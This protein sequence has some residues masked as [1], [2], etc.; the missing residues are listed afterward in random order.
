LGHYDWFFFR[1][2][3]DKIRKIVLCQ[4]KITFE[5]MGRSGKSSKSGS[6]IE[7]P[8]MSDSMS[9]S[10]FNSQTQSVSFV[11][12][13]NH[14]QH[15]ALERQMSDLFEAARRDDY[16]TI[17]QLVQG[18]L[19]LNH[20]HQL[21]TGL[22]AMHMA[23]RYGSWQSLDELLMAGAR[24]DIKTYVSFFQVTPLIISAMFAG[25]PYTK[26]ANHEKVIRRL[27]GK[28]NPSE[29]DTPNETRR[30]I[31]S[32]SDIN[33]LDGLGRTALHW[34]SIMGHR[35]PIDLLL[36]LG[37]D[38]DIRDNY[39][40]TALRY[41]VKCDMELG[42]GFQ[43]I[44][45]SML[46][47]TDLNS[48]DNKGQTILHQVADQAK[49]R[50]PF[51]RLT[52]KDKTTDEDVNIISLADGRE[53]ELIL[54]GAKH[55]RAKIIQM[56]IDKGVDKG[57][58]DENN[59]RASDLAVDQEFIKMLEVEDDKEV[60]AYDSNEENNENAEKEKAKEQQRHENNFKEYGMVL[61]GE[62]MKSKRWGKRDEYPN[63]S[64]IPSSMARESRRIFKK[65]DSV[66]VDPFLRETRE[67][68][69]KSL[70][71]KMQLEL[72]IP[73]ENDDE[74]DTYEAQAKERL[75][76][77]EILIRLLRRMDNISKSTKDGFKDL[78][79]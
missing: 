53:N 75:K 17:R 16:I 20:T 43:D 3:K 24:T 4:K 47:K 1:V 22:N 68:S 54:T 50:D 12:F 71:K 64:D 2:D 29:T 52:V 61:R 11:Q 33:E 14:K 78:L 13:R 30:S 41:A 19:S 51:T 77:R 10:K 39:G 57:I 44:Y 7:G 34:A 28:R 36:E 46:S 72:T 55:G 15:P 58:K 70:V 31:H 65:K 62:L 76:I 73:I 27:V 63:F 79:P 26:F 5:K 60:E 56:L 66:M 25:D 69:I 8:T 40:Y 37:A 67:V 59:Y 48:I 21:V 38:T 35:K 23:A 18:T 9:T 49:N 45:Q 74:R 32:V 42:G 6:E